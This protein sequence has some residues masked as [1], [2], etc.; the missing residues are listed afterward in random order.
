M[1]T[2]RENPNLLKTGQKYGALYTIDLILKVALNVVWNMLYFDNAKVTCCCVSMG[3][4]SIFVLLT[5]KVITRTHHI[6]YLVQFLWRRIL[7]CLSN[8]DLDWIWK[9]AKYL[10]ND[11]C[12]AWLMKITNVRISR[13]LAEIRTVHIQNTSLQ[14]YRRVTLLIA[15]GLQRHIFRPTVGSSGPHFSH[16]TLCVCKPTKSKWKVALSFRAAV[17]R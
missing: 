13:A 9:V 10:S 2:C 14:L 17:I 8:Y 15:F 7:E 5:L 6:A 3:T 4:L 16:S 12:L 1:K 11:I